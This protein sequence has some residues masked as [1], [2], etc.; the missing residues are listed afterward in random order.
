MADKL[1]NVKTETWHRI[2]RDLRESGF[3]EVYRYE[4]ADAGIDYSRYDL[5]SQADGELVVFEWD[6]WTEGEIRAAPARLEA[7]R[8]KY[9]LAAPPEAGD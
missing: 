5:L 4:G 9:R 2:M 1:E 3:I 6:N 7:L 8:E